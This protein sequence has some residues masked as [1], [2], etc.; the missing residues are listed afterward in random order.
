MTTDDEVI[1]R[2][3]NLIGGSSTGSATN[4]PV[5]NAP[6]GRAATLEFAG[7]QSVAIQRSCEGFPSVFEITATEKFPGFNRDVPIRPGDP[8]QVMVS[9]GSGRDILVSGY[10]DRV[11][12]FMTAG[13]HGISIVGRGK[14]QDLVDCSIDWPTGQFNNQTVLRIAQQLAQPFGISVRQIGGE[15]IVIPQLV[16]MQ[17]ETPYEVIERIARFAGLLVYEDEAGNVILSRVGTERMATGAV[18]GKNVERAHVSYSMDERFSIYRVRRLTFSPF[19][20]SGANPEGDIIAT[21]ADPNVPRFRLRTIIA[22]TPAGLG[23]DFAVA[24]GEWEASRRFGRS[25]QIH[26]TID[27]WRDGGGNLWAPNTAIPLDLPSIKAPG[28]PEPKWI[29]ATVCF[30]RDEKGTHADLTIMPA[31]AFDILPIPLT[32]FLN[33][34]PF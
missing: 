33:L 34:G 17:I 20:D 19:S 3:G 22:E 1:I 23:L 13:Q 26:V 12:P 8:C 25:T 15:D 9:R 32:P 11:T 27:N 24:R 14:G 31:D 4:G 30:R 28:V 6:P 16:V 2:A 21:V 5:V 18:E 10:I 7:W 29:I